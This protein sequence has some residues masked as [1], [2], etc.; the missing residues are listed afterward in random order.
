MTDDALNFLVS[1][2]ARH[3]RL[4]VLFA[5]IVDT[6][7]L[8]RRAQQAEVPVHRIDLH[9]SAVPSSGYAPQPDIL[10]TNT[11]LSASGFDH[12]FSDDSYELPEDDVFEEDFYEPGVLAAERGGRR[13]PVIGDQYAATRPSTRIN[14]SDSMLGVSTRLSAV[15]AWGAA[16]LAGIRRGNKQGGRLLLLGCLVLIVLLLLLVRNSRDV[17]APNVGQSVVEPVLVAVPPPPA[18]L[19][20][21]LPV[22]GAVDKGSDGKSG[23]V[24]THTQVSEPSSP[25]P[26]VPASAEASP[27]SPAPQPAVQERVA[28]AP[29]IPPQPISERPTPKARSVP[30]AAPVT[31]KHWRAKPDN[32]TVQIAAAHGEA[33]IRALEARLPAGQPHYVHRTI[34]DGKPWFILIYGS[35]SSKKAASSARESL[36]VEIRKDSTPWVRKQGEV[37]TQ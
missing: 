4:T 10:K 12:T 36:A 25:T 26:A 31:E 33:N 32:F 19:P 7:P 35:F 27:I 6:R 16:T 37:F 24:D 17:G 3:S 11:P 2:M 5:G 21:P 14:V 34:R 15:Q 29:T 8:L 18:Q 9:D 13:E 28:A 20:A 1:M 22:I 30:G 23:V